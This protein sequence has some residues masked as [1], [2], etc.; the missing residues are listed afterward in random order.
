MEQ[1]H[2]RHLTPSKINPNLTL[3]DLGENSIFDISAIAGL[4]N[5]TELWLDNNSISDL[6][7][8]IANTGLRRGNTVDVDRN[9]LNNASISIYI[10]TLRGR[11]VTVKLYRHQS[12]TENGKY[13]RPPTSAMPL[14]QVLGKARGAIITADE[15][16]W[17]TG[18]DATNKNITNLTGLEAGY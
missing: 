6:S 17:L 10:P 16:A 8:L 9:P 4:T 11:G 18:L 13:T 1:L 12:A 2:I 3:L 5:L 7:P 15:M 14:R